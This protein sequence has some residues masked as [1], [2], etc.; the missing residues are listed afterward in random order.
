MRLQRYLCSLRQSCVLG[1]GRSFQI[2]RTAESKNNTARRT[3]SC[4]P[5]SSGTYY[6][7]PQRP[8]VSNVNRATLFLC[9]YYSF[10]SFFF[11]AP[12][13]AVYNTFEMYTLLNLSTLIFTI[14][15]A[16][17]PAIGHPALE[18]ESLFD[19]D[20]EPLEPLPNNEIGNVD[21]FYTDQDPMTDVLA[22]APLFTENPDLS[23]QA[24]TDAIGTDA[25]NSELLGSLDPPLLLAAGEDWDW[26]CPAG[27]ESFCCSERGVTILVPTD[28]G[29]CRNCRSFLY[30]P[31]NFPIIPNYHR[32]TD[33][34]KSPR[35]D[36]N[37]PC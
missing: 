6:W 21:A 17:L 28:F 14:V 35:P 2:S 4:P 18:N 22:L 16:I 5:R 37:P 15:F 11:F 13:A 25:P 8:F 7:M 12:I 19:S 9:F 32:L 20:S 1:Q 33:F 30:L 34:L 36:V 3:C 10:L 29:D 31:S 24:P 23:F 27:K 26:D